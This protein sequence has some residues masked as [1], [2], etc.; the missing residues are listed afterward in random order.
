MTFSLSGRDVDHFR[1]NAVSGAVLASPSFRPKPTY[2]FLATATDGAGAGRSLQT[3][4]K[5]EVFMAQEFSAPRFQREVLEA[6]EV[7]ED[8]P[9]GTVVARLNQFSSREEQ[10]ADLLYGI[11][12]GNAL[13]WFAVRN[14]SGEV[15]VKR[16][17]D[18]ELAG[19]E[20]IWVK[21]FHRRRP[22]FFS[23]ALLNIRLN[24]VN[25]NPPRFHESL[26]EA[27]VQEEQ[28][29]P[30]YVTEVR[31]ED[32]DN[33]GRSGGVTFSMAEENDFFTVDSE[34]GAVT[35]LKKLDREKLGPEPLRA[36]VVASDGLLSST[37]TVVVRVEDINDNAPLF[38]R[39]YSVNVT[40][41][42][43]V[44]S[45]V[46][47]VETRD[48]DTPPNAKVTY[49]VL[50]MD[51]ADARR[52]FDL[53]SGTGELRLTAP[54]DREIREEYVLDVQASDGAWKLD[55][56]VT[57]LVQDENDNSPNFDH[58]VY[59][60]SLER[61]KGDLDGELV[62]KVH[63]LDRDSPGPN[64][65]IVYSFAHPTDFFQVDSS[66]GA[67]RTSKQLP[68]SS[69]KD[70]V[71]KMVVIASDL[72][73]P[74]RTSKCQVE[75]SVEDSKGE[76]P[77]L[78]SVR[79]LVAIPRSLKPGTIIQS[80]KTEKRSRSGLLYNLAGGNGSSVFEMDKKTGTL[81]LRRA[82]PF[83]TGSLLTFNVTVSDSLSKKLVSSF[84]QDFYVTGENVH[85]PKFP[86]PLTRVYIREDEPVGG[87]IIT[88]ASQDDDEGINGEVSYEIVSGN[89]KGKFKIDP[90]SGRIAVKSELDYE[91]AKQYTLEIR[92][93][94]RGF[95][96]KTST[97]M[98]K[99]LL[100]DVNDNAP[101]FLEASLAGYIKENSKPGTLAAQVEATDAD[102][103]MFSNVEFSFVGEQQRDFEI[104]SKTGMVVSLRTFDY[105]RESSFSLAIEARNPGSEQSA[106]ATLNISVVGENEFV[107]RFIQPVFQF[108]ISESSIPGASV[109]KVEAEDADSGPE[110]EVF[111]YLVGA[112]NVA[113]FVVERNTGVVRVGADGRGLDRESQN[114]Y[115]LRVMA[116]NRGP[117][118]GGDVDEAQVIVQVRDGNDPPVFERASYSAEVR[119]DAAVGS[120]VVTV[121]AVDRDVRPH[122]SLFSY[123]IS[124]GD[125][126][127]RFSIDPASGL[128]E[129][130]AKLDRE[131]VPSYNLTVSAI[132]G[133]SP[134]ATG[135]TLVSVVLSDVNDSPPEL[136]TSKASIKEN[137]PSGSFVAR[138]M[139]TDPDLPPHAGPFSF[140]MM[141]SEDSSSFSLDRL[142]GIL[143]TTEVF[144]RERRSQMSLSIRVSDGG[145][146]R[147]SRVY[148]FAVEVLDEN[149]NP[150]RPRSLQVVVKVFEGTFAG[151]DVFTALPTDLD[152]QVMMQVLLSADITKHEFIRGHRKNLN[153]GG[154]KS[155]QGGGKNMASGRG[156]I[157]WDRD[158]LGERE[159]LK[160]D[161]KF[162]FW[163]I[164]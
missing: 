119:E 110:G 8:V 69:S 12:G 98:V 94:D 83:D 107:P 80:Y 112:S 29:P 130:A 66:T 121:A 49:S 37:A 96:A 137:S 133:G 57:I 89:E 82:V 43:P 17:P 146:P 163:A 118:R 51:D 13:D 5:V 120:S 61:S 6:A 144:D 141:P 86:S 88:M 81:K 45:V 23:A 111:F 109:G 139:A 102:S 154:Q 54:L 73:S 136:E 158:G 160:N 26:V 46:L 117:I 19:Q 156:T 92:A 162:T 145:Q 150:S 114:R 90:E 123:S 62:G 68:K 50:T 124:Y 15:V 28:Y 11:A 97:T 25:D 129:V 20:D 85:G 22:L 116:K 4:R 128:I 95:F 148:P 63:A 38:A 143:R 149:D 47:T 27:T 135:T 77:V 44:G 140:E 115:V 32:A 70:D 84:R 157:S 7:D 55:T 72:G 78:D 14:G 75:V 64:S 151:G 3:T 138:I 93:R 103:Q 152:D 1:V 31:A 10:Q 132:D 36:L 76:S 74:P 16:Q 131:E 122:N 142:S 39:L 34:S 105:E 108:A 91:E 21:I 35:C 159:I 134:P 71:Y 127:G 65:E 104:D 67:I 60:F 48:A 24:N 53:D 41:D 155:W 30:F 126:D 9:V 106:R 18:F 147:R 40:E 79:P 100:Q 101:E 33:E 2:S 113:G 56:T 58:D 42:A 153:R 87:A 52:T 59:R 164:F 99:V 125:D 161:R